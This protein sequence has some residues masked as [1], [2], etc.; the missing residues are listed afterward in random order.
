MLLINV[1]SLFV[2]D[3]WVDHAEYLVAEMR[4]NMSLCRSVHPSVY[5]WLVGPSEIRIVGKRVEISLRLFDISIKNAI[6]DKLYL[7]KSHLIIHTVVRICPSSV[8]S[9]HTFSLLSTCFKSQTGQ[10][11]ISLFVR[12]HVASRFGGLLS[13]FLPLIQCRL[14]TTIVADKNVIFLFVI[15]I[16]F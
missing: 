4:L 16:S 9:T 2:S 8:F 3:V 10:L 5:R 14:R 12:I 6:R 15:T 13:L 7:Y 11:W 1:N